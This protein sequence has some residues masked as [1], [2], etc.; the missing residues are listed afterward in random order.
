[1]PSLIAEK[2][3]STKKQLTDDFRW[4]KKRRDILYEENKKLLQQNERLK[5]E[6]NKLFLE[7]NQKNK[8]LIVLLESERQ[9]N[10]K[11]SK[12]LQG[13]DEKMETLKNDISFAEE[14]LSRQNAIKEDIPEIENKKQG[15]VDNIAQ[16][17]ADYE[18]IKAKKA[19]ESSKYIEEK[20]ILE[21]KKQ[22]FKKDESELWKA[23]DV[24]KDWHSNIQAYADQT[25]KAVLALK[26]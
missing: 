12:I 10:L 19:I 14:E 6:N 26:K 4:L 21:K 3:V 1:M 7:I 25:E 22:R 17:K 20:A 8:D 2:I 11:A 13:L 15:L 23:R 16:L 9:L 18:K 24:N 5:A